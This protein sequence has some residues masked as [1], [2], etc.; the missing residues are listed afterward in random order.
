[1]TCTLPKLSFSFFICIVFKTTRY[2]LRLGLQL[3]GYFHYLPI[4]FSINQWIIFIRCHKNIF[5]IIS[6]NPQ[7]PIHCLIKQLLLCTSSAM[8]I[9]GSETHFNLR[10]DSTHRCARMCTVYQYALT[11]VCTLSNLIGDESCLFSFIWISFWLAFRKQKITLQ[12]NYFT[13][14]PL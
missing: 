10:D 3:A 9:G 8:M 14:I 7:I 2:Y 5:I 4:L 1:M 6:Q 13:P 11:C 12:Y